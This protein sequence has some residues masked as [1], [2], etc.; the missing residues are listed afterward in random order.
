MLFLNGFDQWFHISFWW[1][2]HLEGRHVSKEMTT[3]QWF[4][5]LKS[6][7]VFHGVRQ[8]SETSALIHAGQE[9]EDQDQWFPHGLASFELK[10]TL[11]PHLVI[12][13][14]YKAVHSFNQSKFLTCQTN[15]LEMKDVN[16]LS[17]RSS[18]STKSILKFDKDQCFS[19][20]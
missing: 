8:R 19:N 18:S 6:I 13:R 7:S 5:T 2:L 15:S 20:T 11:R 3:E 17:Q 14:L 16:F 12:D 1:F 9:T 10:W 4:Q